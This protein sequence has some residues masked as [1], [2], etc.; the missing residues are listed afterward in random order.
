MRSDNRLV[1]L[2]CT[3]CYA[4]CIF[5]GSLCLAQVRKQILLS[6]VQRTNQSQQHSRELQ[7]ACHLF[8]VILF[9][10]VL[11]SMW[12][13][14][15]CVLNFTENSCKCIHMFICIL[16][17]CVHVFFYTSKCSPSNKDY[18]FWQY[19]FHFLHGTSPACCHFTLEGLCGENG[20]Y[21]IFTNVAVVWYSPPCFGPVD[22]SAVSIM[23]C[24]LSSL[25]F[26][27]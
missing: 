7:P 11:K 26:L 6:A 8:L 19:H 13:L 24:F 22:K 15:K 17:L 4:L 1:F 21:L 25:H 5:A 3:S 14:S 16:A 18:K 10:S 2:F 23:S 9:P 27:Q 20:N 12:N